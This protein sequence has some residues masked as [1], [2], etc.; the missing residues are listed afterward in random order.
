VTQSAL[1]L[2]PHLGLN[3]LPGKIVNEFNQ[4]LLG[5]KKGT[6]VDREEWCLA[7]VEESLGFL[8]GHFFVQDAF[9]MCP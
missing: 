5:I 3:T 8:T 7:R 1:Q 4:L 9:S 2:A 6:P